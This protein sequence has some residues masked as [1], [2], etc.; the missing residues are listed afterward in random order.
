M[1]I[2]RILIVR[3]DRLG[4]VLLTTPVARRLKQVYPGAKITWLVRGYAAPLLENN[5][6]ADEILVDR[7]GPL[8]E[9]IGTLWQREF[10]A[11]IVAYPRW[12]AAWAVWRAGIPV[13]IG[14]ASKPYSALFNRRV[15]QHRSKGEKHEA[16]YNLELLAPLG[17]PF[18]RVAT[19]MEL[20]AEERLRARQFLESM[21][22]SFKR[23]VVCIHPGSGG[24]SERW[25]LN[26]FMELGDKLQEAGFDVVVTAGP[27][28]NYQNV[29]IDQMRRIP[30]FVV[31]GS[32]SVR[33]LGAILS[34]MNLMVSNSTGPLHL[35][36]ALGIPTVSIYSP[37][38][39][40]H[41]RRWGPYPAYP[42]N[43]PRHGVFMPA[44][45][46]GIP[47]EMKTVRIDDVFAACREKLELRQGVS[48]A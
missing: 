1:A 14:P 5:P 38:A 44:M 6:D 29:M 24:S 10:D 3:T 43:D 34:Q 16:D 31:G 35:A 26:Y 47:D 39:T 32:V 45:V 13:R 36:V 11:A 42:E 27:G 28:E 7:G 40:C 8:K 46:N 12:R 9:L 21:R 30:V 23:P 37:I 17:V 33:Q 22:I 18:G 48:V 19:R 41:P 2:N 15:W 4:D 20:T 25:P